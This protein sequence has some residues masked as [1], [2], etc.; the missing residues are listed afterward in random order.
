MRTATLC[1]AAWLSVTAT[2]SAQSGSF[3][4]LYVGTSVA[5]APAGNNDR[6]EAGALIGY[7]VEPAQNLVL[8]AEVQATLG[9]DTLR[10]P[11]TRAQLAAH[12]GAIVGENVLLFGQAG[13]EVEQYN[14]RNFG[15]GPA[16]NF[17]P[18]TRMFAGVGVEF[19]ANENVSL[20][21]E[22]VGFREVTSQFNFSNPAARGSAGVIFRLK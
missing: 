4:G 15:P 10:T 6:F 17:P 1:L 20:R 9:F 11:Y 14:S 2:T 16:P 18:T 12:A 13:V 7:R 3:D 22:A 5:T 19:A 21:A 8:G